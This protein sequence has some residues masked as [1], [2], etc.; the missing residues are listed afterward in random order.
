LK[1]KN[2][3]A[4]SKVQWKNGNRLILT[5]DPHSYN[6]L[7]NEYKLGTDGK[8]VVVKHYTEFF[9]ELIRSGKLTFK[10]KL[11]GKVTYHD[12]CYLGRYNGV[13]EEPRQVIT[14]LGLELVE[15]PR[16]RSRSHCCGAGGGRMWMEDTDE[17]KERPAENRVKEAASLAGVGTIVVACP[18]DLA[19]FKDAVKTTGNEGRVVVKDIAELVAEAMEIQ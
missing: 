10:K 1:D 16:N 8:N 7:K 5:T 4:F 13:Y 11:S 14:A 15:M 9:F 6:T 3:E 17:I 2:H 18:K 12:P 19:M